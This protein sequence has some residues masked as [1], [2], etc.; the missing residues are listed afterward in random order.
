MQETGFDPWVG[1]IPWRR[2]WQPS[3]VFLPGKSHGQRSLAGYSPWSC[4]ELDMTNKLTHTHTEGFPSGAS[5]KEL[6]CQSRRHETW[7]RSLGQEDPLEKGMQLTSVF[8]SIPRT[9]EPVRLPSI[10][11]QWVKQ[12]WS[13]LA[14]MCIHRAQVS[15]YLSF[16]NARLF[17]IPQTAAH[18][19]P[20]SLRFSRQ[21]YWNGLPFPYPGDLPDPGIEP[22]S[23]ALQA[24]S[25][26]TELQ[27]KPTKV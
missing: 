27:G 3:P 23:P 25:L 22:R 8:F 2:K 4:K 18:Q 21:G 19:S 24:D 16:S 20:L 26:L 17:A 6:P 9:D 7:V 12:D 10:E 5:G 14:H 15:K 13:N 11:L 1:K